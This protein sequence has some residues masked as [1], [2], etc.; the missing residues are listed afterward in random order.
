MA[1]FETK[2]REKK[3]QLKVSF[4]EAKVEVFADRDIYLLGEIIHNPEVNAQLAAMGI[5][6]LSASGRDAAIE[7][8]AQLVESKFDEE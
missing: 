1:D 8:L 4:P 6:T 7:A 5:R 2:A 3:L